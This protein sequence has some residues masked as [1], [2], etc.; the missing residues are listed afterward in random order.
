MKKTSRGITFFI[1]MI[2][3]ACGL[4]Y[5]IIKGGEAK[6]AISIASTTTSGYSGFSLFCQTMAEHFQSSI[7]LLLLQ[8]IAILLVCRLFGWLF[9]KIGQPTVIGEIVAGIVLGPSVLGHLLPDIS[10]FLFRPDS[11]NNISTLSEFGLILF[12]FAIGMELDISEVKK[13]IG[14]TLIISQTSI[15]VSFCFG[16]LAA[17]ISYDAY[18]SKYTTFLP[19]ALFVGIAMSIT[20]FPVLARIIQEKGLTRSHL[21]VLALTSAA[22]KDVISWCI[23]A[24]VIA[25]AQAGSLVSAFYSIGFSILYLLFMFYAVR[26]FMKMVGNVYTNKEVIGKGIVA[27]VFLLL[28]ISSYLTEILGLHALFGAFFAGVVMPSNIKFRKILTEKV[29]DVSL[30]LFL[31]LF[32]VSTG[33]RTEIG[34]LNTPELWGMCGIF[35]LIAIVGMFGGTTLATRFTGESWYDSLNMGALMNTR[36]LMELVILTIGYDM[37]ILPPSI[38]VMLVL[39]TLITTFMTT[40]LVSFINLCYHTRDKIL[41]HRMEETDKNSFKVLLSFGRAGNGQVMLNVAH[42]LFARSKK[43]LN[44]T[45]LHLTVGSDVNPQQTDKFEEI[46]FAPIIRDAKALGMQM[47]TRYEIA[48]EAVPYICNI[49]NYEGFDFLLIGSGLNQSNNPN[50]ISASNYR[51]LLRDLWLKQLSLLKDKTKTFVM[52]SRCDVGV[53]INR[54]FVKATKVLIIIRNDGDLFLLNYASNLLLTNEGTAD[55]LCLNP[56]KFDNIPSSDKNIKLLSS[57]RFS[58]ELLRNYNFMFVSY[59]TWQAS[60]IDYKKE[61]EVIPSTLVLNHYIE[62]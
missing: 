27:S 51:G 50:D 28:I 56:I 42:Q 37:H 61:L 33:L 2:L 48:S 5:V 29:E 38:F 13:K 22:S 4:I 26:P 10:A 11:L 36:G 3:L 58:C 1:I 47:K 18:A 53:F 15:A 35:T 46:S 21:G 60:T 32:F 44:L 62:K 59:Q 41:R 57:A 40:P 31:P 39:M 20:A 6:Q 9:H 45:A 23:L 34:L 25:I 52:Q 19:F 7:G 12:M 17:Y 43:K 8:I 30:A 16:I 24:V 54:N 55:I 49:V 14:E